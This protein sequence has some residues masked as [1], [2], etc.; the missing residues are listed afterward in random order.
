[1]I[2]LTKFELKTIDE[3]CAVLPIDA[4]KD[5]IVPLVKMVQNLTQDKIKHFDYIVDKIEIKKSSFDPLT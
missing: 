5:E 2:N 3:I 4:K 1:M